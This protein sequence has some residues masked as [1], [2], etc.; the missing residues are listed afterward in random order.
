MAAVHG[1]GAEAAVARVF[2]PRGSPHL[3][4]RPDGGIVFGRWEASG[5]GPGEELLVIRRGRDDLEVHCH[6]G[7]AAVEAVVASLERLGAGRSDWATWLRDRGCAEVEIEA[8]EALSRA[9]GPKAARILSRQLAGALQADCDGI[10]R[11]LSVGRTAE[12]RAII[13]RLLRASRVGRRLTRPWRVVLAG[14]VNAGKSSLLNAIAGHA[15]SIVSPEPGTTRDLVETRLV[16][17]GWEVDLVDTAGV[18]DGAPTATAVSS[19]E[20]AGM[21]RAGVA[22]AEADLVVHVVDPW[23]RPQGDPVQ[24]VA[25]GGRAEILA[26]TKADLSTGP[27]PIVAGRPVWTSGLTGEGVEELVTRIVR[28]LVPEE[29]DEPE[30]LAGPVPFTGRQVDLLTLWRERCIACGS[31]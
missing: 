25:S 7:L 23:E 10:E 5:D 9:C 6:G 26:V 11:L 31:A 17:D 27:R 1:T 20:R 13:E 8:R 28:A 14:R 4:E 15:R 24:P 29:A 3:A 12:A 2:R 22:C 21:D 16:L 18:R 30:L 19:I